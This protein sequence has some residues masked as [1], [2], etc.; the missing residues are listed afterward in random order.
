MPITILAVY[1]SVIIRM[2]L[3]KKSAL[4]SYELTIL[5]QAILIFCPFQVSLNS[6]TELFSNFLKSSDLF[7]SLPSMPNGEVRTRD[8]FYD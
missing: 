3:I 8:G 4:N 2:V 1:T 6:V 5:K 7:I